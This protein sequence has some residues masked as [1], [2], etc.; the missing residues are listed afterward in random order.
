MDDHLM[1]D[2]FNR[3]IIDQLIIDLQ[4]QF[5]FRFCVFV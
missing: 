4:L 3:S 1:D 2:H 5:R